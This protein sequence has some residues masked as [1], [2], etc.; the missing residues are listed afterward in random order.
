MAVLENKQV[1][2]VGSKKFIMVAK[3]DGSVDVIE[4]EKN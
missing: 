1:L 3:A 4:V 2:F